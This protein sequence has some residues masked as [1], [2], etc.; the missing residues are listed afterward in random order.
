MT[1]RRTSSRAF[2]GWASGSVPWTSKSRPL[3]WSKMHFLSLPT[4]ATSPRS[5]AC[6]AK[7]GSSYRESAAPGDRIASPARHRV[8]PSRAN[9]SISAAGP[10]VHERGVVDF[11]A[12]RISDAIGIRAYSDS[13]VSI[14][15]RGNVVDNY[16]GEVGARRPA[17]VGHV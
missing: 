15:G 8:H 1:P 16:R 3:R 2:D 11:H 13:F 14:D 4:C 6:A 10:R 5:P 12:R 17:H 7:V 9:V